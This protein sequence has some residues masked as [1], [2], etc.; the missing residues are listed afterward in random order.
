MCIFAGIFL[1]SLLDFFTNKM[2][3]SPP[4]FSFRC[5]IFIPSMENVV[6]IV[7]GVFVK[8]WGNYLSNTERY[9]YTLL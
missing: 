6:V 4:L 1:Y 9:W 7:Q 2:I 3:Y 5:L 8:E